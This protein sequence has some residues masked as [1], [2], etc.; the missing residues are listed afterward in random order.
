MGRFLTVARL[1][2]IH[3]RHSHAVQNSSG[4][5]PASL[6]LRDFASSA[7]GGTVPIQSLCDHFANGGLVWMEAG[8]I[9]LEQPYQFVEQ[10]V[11]RGVRVLIAFVIDHLIPGR[12]DVNTWVL[13]SCKLAV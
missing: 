3:S 7:A 9:F 11:F 1:A 8:R 6:P 5:S 4:R 10:N 2:R 13:P 12:T